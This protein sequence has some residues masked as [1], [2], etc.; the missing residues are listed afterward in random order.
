MWLFGF[1][2]TA[3]KQVMPVSLVLQSLFRF[4][5]LVK[6]ETAV[7]TSDRNINQKNIDAGEKPLL[8]CWA[9]WAAKRVV[10][11]PLISHQ[12]KKEHRNNNIQL[13]IPISKG[14]L[15]KMLPLNSHKC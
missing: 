4:K 15:I 12:G 8:S 14:S 11:S 2:L 3:G 6:R 7:I 10:C 1:V 9:G 5:E 13:V